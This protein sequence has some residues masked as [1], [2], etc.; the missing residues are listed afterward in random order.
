MRNFFNI[1]ILLGALQ[2]LIVGALLFLKKGRTHANR[3]LAI[4]I[5]IISMACFNIYLM[6]MGARYS[7]S[8][9][10][11]IEVY[12]PFVLAM[13]IGPLI[14]FYVKANLN[15]TFRINSSDRIHF[16]PLILDLVPNI[17][18]ILFAIGLTLGFLSEDSR[19]NW[20]YFADEYNTYVDIPRW[21][22]I[23]IY[24]LLAKREIDL[25]SLNNTEIEKSLRWPRQFVFVFVM[26]QLIWLFHLI[27]YVIP[28]VS[29]SLLKLVG[30]YPIYIPLAVMVYWLGIYG[31]LFSQTKPPETSVSKPLALIPDVVNHT[32]NALRKAMEEEK[33]FLDPLFNLTALVH[34]TGIQQKIISSVL[35]QH[36]GKSFN[37]FMNE[38]RVNEVKEKLVKS[39]YNHLTI[40]GIALDCGF[41]SQ[42]TF[43]RTFKNIVGQ[44]PKEFQSAHLA[45]PQ[46]ITAKTAQI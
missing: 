2:G 12:V 41:N 25:T 18:F 22:S 28:G 40:T 13:P 4:L 44:S 36:L 46:K 16:Y 43:Q 23:S 26:F 32:K 31:Y 35:N 14:F 1:I 11:M 29:D 38:Y 20:R 8:F 19:I 7:N 3:I 34:H 10:A 37:D 5:L 9:W 30:W 39:E 21:I 15:S 27:P 6:E 17:A 45:S 42:A 33:L 24:V